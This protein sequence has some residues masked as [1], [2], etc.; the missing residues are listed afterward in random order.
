M[1]RRCGGSSPTKEAKYK[2]HLLIER[3]NK[4]KNLERIYKRLVKAS[5]LAK[6]KGKKRVSYFFEKYP[7]VESYMK[8]IKLKKVVGEE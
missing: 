5:K 4:L 1:N 8:I 6:E 2:S 7:S 3:Q